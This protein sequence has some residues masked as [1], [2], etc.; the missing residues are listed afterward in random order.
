MVT[1]AVPLSL[2]WLCST[3]PKRAVSPRARKR[4]KAERSSTGLLIR[5]S[6]SPPP[7][8]DA[9]SAATA[10]MR[11]VV[12]LSGSVTSVVA[13]AGGVGDERAEPEGEH[14]EVL[15]H[16]RARPRVRAP[17]AAF[18]AA[19]RDEHAAA[20][21]VLPRVLGQDLQRLVHPHRA[22]DVRRLVAGEREHA[23]VHGPERHL[24]RRAAPL[25]VLAPRP[26]CAPSPPAGTPRGRAFTVTSR[27]L[28]ASSTFSSA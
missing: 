21:D 25:A 6:R 28:A 12:R 20:D 15:A 14:A 13:A 22:Q 2:S 26:R 4:G 18:V 3:A 7:K 24:R 19:L 23:V 27:R 16:R 1:M 5:I 10:M 11:Y 9:L 8:R 17:A